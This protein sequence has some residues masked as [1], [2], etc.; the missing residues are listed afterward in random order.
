MRIQVRAGIGAGRALHDA[1][2]RRLRFALGRF[3]RRIDGVR[4]R[5][6]DVNGPR[7][8][9]DQECQ[10]AVRLARPADLVVI[11]DRDSDPHA[12][13]ARAV[14]RAARAVGRVIEHARWGRTPRRRQEVLS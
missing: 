4:V 13:L 12:A 2:Q 7:G 6:H 10:V 9:V 14:D 3:E 8:G 5:F 11:E 1:A